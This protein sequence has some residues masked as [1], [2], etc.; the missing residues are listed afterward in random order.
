MKQSHCLSA[1]GVV[2]LSVCVFESFGAP[3]KN[4]DGNEKVIVQ[5]NKSK[6]NMTHKGSST[7]YIKLGNTGLAEKKN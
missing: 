4:K 5:K 6:S 7:Q 1:V 3:I 2:L